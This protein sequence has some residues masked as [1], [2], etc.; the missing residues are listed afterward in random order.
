[1][2]YHQNALK[3]VPFEAVAYSIVFKNLMYLKAE[4]FTSQILARLRIF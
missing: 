4:A 1:M 2:T 3:E